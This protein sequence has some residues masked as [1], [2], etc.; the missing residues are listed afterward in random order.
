MWVFL[1]ID[2]IHGCQSNKDHPKKLSSGDERILR[3]T[4]NKFQKRN[5]VVYIQTKAR[6]R[7]LGPCLFEFVK[8]SSRA[9]EECNISL[10]TISSYKIEIDVK[11][12][13]GKRCLGIT[14]WW[15]VLSF[16]FSKLSRLPG[17][18]PLENICYLV[19]KQLKKNKF[20]KNKS[21]RGTTCSSSINMLRKI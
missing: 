9:F 16:L 3:R 4:F 5:V 6:R 7:T 18:N 8:C 19:F 1:L 21:K 20:C 2:V 12:S 14:R 13:G 11:H 15:N 17:L 10:I